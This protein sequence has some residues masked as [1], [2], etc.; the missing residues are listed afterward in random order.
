VIEG[1]LAHE[2]HPLIA[3][4]YE[5]F[6]VTGLTVD[7]VAPELEKMRENYF[8]SIR[9]YRGFRFQNGHAETNLGSGSDFGSSFLGLKRAVILDATLKGG[10]VSRTPRARAK[11]TLPSCCRIRYY[12][13]ETRVI[14]SR[15]R[16]SFGSR[17]S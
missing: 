12:R 8:L 13:N 15:F 2:I 4:L 3:S 11:P 5:R 14:A 1:N 6:G 17:L 16:S 9:S 10:A 7:R